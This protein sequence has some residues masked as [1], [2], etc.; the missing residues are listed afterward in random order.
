MKSKYTHR[1]DSV[2]TNSGATPQ[3]FDQGI[4]NAIMS[5]IAQMD[6]YS[7]EETTITEIS[8]GR[9]VGR[10]IHGEPISVS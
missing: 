4:N 9:V 10:W 7:P 6:E 8:T 5:A 1:T 3:T 2:R